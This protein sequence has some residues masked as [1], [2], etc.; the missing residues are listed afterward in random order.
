MKL[1]N[2]Q[3]F[4]ALEVM[5][6]AEEKGMLGYAIMRNRKKLTDELR[7]YSAKRDELLAEY[8]EA[9]GDG[10]YNIKGENV[11]KFYEALRPFDELT[12]DVPVMQVSAEVFYSGNLTSREMYVLEWMCEGE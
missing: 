2:A 10:R 9:E 7:E 5:A 4:N 1:T 12:V 8:G 6:S 11:A 3:M